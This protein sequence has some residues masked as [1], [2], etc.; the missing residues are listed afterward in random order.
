MNDIS[1][2]NPRP[3]KTR[4]DFLKLADEIEGLVKERGFTMSRMSHSIDTDTHVSRTGVLSLAS[5]GGTCQHVPR[6]E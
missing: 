2:K 1:K 3:N 4:E 5:R 6:L